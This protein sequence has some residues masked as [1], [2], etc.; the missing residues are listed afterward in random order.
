MVETSLILDQLLDLSSFTM[1]FSKVERK[2]YKPQT[3]SFETDSEHSFQL[4]MVCWY[5]NQKLSLGY[6]TEIILKYSLVHDLVEVY[7]GDTFFFDEKAREDKEDRERI[8]LE[9]IAERFADFGEMIDSIKQYEA[10]EDDESKF[11]YAMDKIIPLI[12]IYLDS[13]RIWKEIGISYEKLIE[14]KDSK[15]KISPEVYDLFLDLQN[16]LLLNKQNLFSA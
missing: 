9:K 10:R 12:N 7:A 8:A 2:V 5:V 16:L 14:L 4:A 15:V 13:G 6:S 11:V 1:D 3:E